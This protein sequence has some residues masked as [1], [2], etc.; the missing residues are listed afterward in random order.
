MLICVTW[1]CRCNSAKEEPSVQAFLRGPQSLPF[2][3]LQVQ[4]MTII[5]T[6]GGPANADPG[7]AAFSKGLG[8]AN[9]D[10]GPDVGPSGDSGNRRAGADCFR[11]QV[12]CATSSPHVTCLY[13]LLNVSQQVTR[14]QTQ[15]HAT[16][17]QKEAMSSRFLRGASLVPALSCSFPYSASCP[18]GHK[19]F[20]FPTR[21]PR[22]IWLFLAGFSFRLIAT[23]ALLLAFSD[24]RRLKA[25]ARALS[26]ALPLCSVCMRAC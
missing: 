25:L 18:G 19:C 12:N 21:R 23:N 14:F 26:P 2:G 15:P 16:W 5:G 24:G 20:G 13:R 10:V 7:N 6:V 1:A 3:M 22:P 4:F 17:P 8:W 9:F 11:S